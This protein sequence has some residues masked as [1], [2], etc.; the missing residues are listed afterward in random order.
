MAPID[1]DYLQ[2]EVFQLS[3]IAHKSHDRSFATEANI[4]IIVNDINDQRPEPLF[5]EYTVDIMEET[6]LTLNFEDEFGFHDRD[7]VNTSFRLFSL[8]I[9]RQ[10]STLKSLELFH[11]YLTK[12]NVLIMRRQPSIANVLI[13]LYAYLEIN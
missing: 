9:F 7:L 2:R 1:R 13:N 8:K 10:E 12:R 5:K 6:P 4:F 11:Y 3:I